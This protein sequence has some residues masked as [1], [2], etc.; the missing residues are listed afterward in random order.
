MATSAIPETDRERDN[1]NGFTEVERPLL[2]QLMAMGWDFIQGDLDYPG[3]TGRTSFGETV[4]LERLRAAF[5]RINKD[6]HGREWLDELTID[7]AVRELLRPEG[8]GLLELNRSFTTRLQTGVRV[9]VAQGPRSGE[10]V[11]LHVIA[12][13]PERLKDN[14]FLAIDQFQVLIRSTP[15]T[16]RPDVVLFVN[17]LPLVVIEC[18]GRNVTDPLEEAV[19]QLLHYSNQRQLD[20]G[21]REGIPELFHFNALLVGTHYDRAVASTVGD[22]GD[23]FAEWK[24]TSPLPNADVLGELG[25]EGGVL[26]GQETLVA[27]MLRPAHL[28]DLMRNFTVWDTDEGRLVKKVARY[29]QFRAVHRAV[30]HLETGKTRRETGDMDTRGGVVWQTQGSGK[31]LAMAFLVRK[32]RT[33]ETLRSFKVVVVSDRTSLERQ[34]RGT[35]Q[36]SGENLRPSDEEKKQNLPQIEIVQRILREKG[37]DV[38]FCMMQ[39]NQDIDRETETLTA[40]VPAYVRKDPAGGLLSDREG[41]RDPPEQPERGPKTKFR[42]SDADGARRGLE[43][44]IQNVTRTLRATIPKGGKVEVVNDDERIILLIDEC[45]RS[46]A[47]D[48]HA[49]MMGALPNAAKIGFTG[50]PIFREGDANTLRIFG[51][52]IDKYGMTTSWQ[53]GAT[54]EILYEGRSA[55]GL[56]ERTERLDEAF[57]NRFRHYTDEERAIIRQRY[58]NEPDILEAPRLIEEKARDMMLHYAGEVLPNGFKAQVVAVS[59]KA[60]VRYQEALVKARA[61]LLAAVEALPAETLALTPDELATEPE[62]TQYLARVHKHRERLRRLEI[63]AVISGEHKD[64]LSWKQWTDEVERE[65]NEQLFKLPF[66]HE[67]AEKRSPLGILVVKNML[68]TGFDAPVEQV[69]YLDR[70]MADHE[71]LQAIARVN[72]RKAGKPRGYVVDYAGVADAL[73]AAIKAVRE[74]EEE[75]GG[76]DGGGGIISLHESLPRLR[77]A[78][79][80]VTQVFTTRGVASLLP[81]DPPVQ[82][83]ADPKVRAEFINKLRAFLA[84]LGALFT[85]PESAEFKRDAKILAFIARVASNVY[86]DPQLLLIG[87]EAKVKQLVDTYIAAQGIDPVIPPT[88]IMDVK[89]GEEMRKYG[90]SRTRASAMQHAIRLQLAIKLQEDPTFYKTLSE[91]LEAILLELKDR[92]D[93]Q[94]AAME[95]LL[96]EMAQGETAVRVEG[97]EPKVHGPFFGLLRQECEKAGV[98]PLDQNPAELRRVVDLTRDVV[99]HIQQEIRTVDFWQDSNSRRQL[100]NWLYTTVRQTRLIPRNKAEALATQLMEVA[101]NRRRLLVS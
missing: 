39:K 98:P 13:Q 81:I 63:A 67:N 48:F 3:K 32:L 43:A 69:L 6:E 10:E 64:P 25:K 71:L 93:E 24:D 59:R 34:L 101:Y 80:R 65:R 7:R 58:G 26:S 2:V 60:A 83:L 44:G 16:K 76:G 31:S 86:Q 61:D 78:H 17:G 8:R 100:E 62:W 21:E 74:L 5:R 23:Y 84:C 9:A 37:P 88:S 77:E 36:L 12:W 27:G 54:V 53:D 57:N 73:A 94:I 90:S 42:S 45:H 18:K 19:D 72:R 87:V 11:T 70:Q 20:H 85:R 49:Y 1:P 33:V 14:E 91:K 38:V 51:R 95:T 75:N 66:D 50:T 30:H 22:T 15:Y 68:L 46:Q 35:M 99:E 97:I 4:L 41:K 89:F 82:L 55:D 96:H 52:F 29:Q 28:L 47:G 56:V 40:E 79:Q 92:W